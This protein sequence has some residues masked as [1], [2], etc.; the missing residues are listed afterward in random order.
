MLADSPKVSCTAVKISRSIDWL[1]SHQGSEIDLK[2][3]NCSSAVTVFIKDLYVSEFPVPDVKHDA[4]FLAELYLLARKHGR[5]AMA[6]TYLMRFNSA[7]YREPF[8]DK[9]LSDIADFCGPDSCR[10][11][12][13]ALPEE[14]FDNILYRVIE[15]KHE[16]TTKSTYNKFAQKLEG[17]SLFNA[18]FMGRFA[19]EMTSR[20]LKLESKPYPDLDDE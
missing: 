19:K 8:A 9:Y 13:T 12:D 4:C 20:Y 1:T 3:E 17:G 6:R 14:A 16:E 18:V 15:L 5:D 2:N 10:Y 7:L 11:T